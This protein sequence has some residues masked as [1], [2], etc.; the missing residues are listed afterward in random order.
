M[1]WLSPQAGQPDPE[2]SGRTT[3]IID[4]ED[5]WTHMLA[6]QVRHFGMDAEVRRWSEVRAEDLTDFDLV[7][8]GPGPGDPED[9]NEQRMLQI[10]GL[11]QAR[12]DADRPLLAVCLSHQVLASLGGLQIEKLQRPNQGVQIPVDLWGTAAKIGFYNT[13]VARP[14]ESAP[15]L[16]TGRG[17]A[18]L[19]VA[20]D[21][22]DDA[23]VGLRGRR[24]ASLQGHAESVLSKDGLSTLHTLIRHTLLS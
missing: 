2:L 24:V 3:L 11:M 20:T 17:S 10:R 1:F 16:Q 15:V 8:F 21:R 22:M 9:T 19:E 18:P 23:V 13:F 6:H 5:M 12:L 7:L 14:G 4:A